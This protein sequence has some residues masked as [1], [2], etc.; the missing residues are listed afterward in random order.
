MLS[1]ASI[2]ELQI[3]AQTGKLTLRLPLE[4][5]VREQ[6]Q[7]NGVRV[8][9]VRDRHVFALNNLPVKPDHKDPFDRLLIAQSVADG[10]SVVTADPAFRR[11]PASLIY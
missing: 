5:L 7:V 9:P 1:V 3:K 8:L 4:Q 2:W 10:M 6:Q 11:Y